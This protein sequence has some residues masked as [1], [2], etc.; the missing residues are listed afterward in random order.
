MNQID[1]KKLNETSKLI[2]TLR[3]KC[4][5]T[6]CITNFVT[7][8]DC[9][10]SVLA[11]GGSPA[12]AN[13]KEEVTEFVDIAGSLV[14]NI[15]TIFEHDQLAI[16]KAATHAKKVETPV[17]LDPVAVGVTKLRNEITKKIIE[18]SNVSIIRG[19]MSEI[20]AI[21]K[22]FNIV[23]EC[24]MAKGVDVATNDIIT[25]EN[26]KEKGQL[27]K[28]IA[29]KLNT[30]IAVS[31][32]IDIISDGKHSYAIDNGNEIMT[33][34]TGSGCMLTAV[35]GSFM[36]VTTPLNAAII[37]S[38]SMAIAGELAFKTISDNKEGTGSFRTYL[39][40]ELYKIN[41]DTI[42]KYGKLYLIE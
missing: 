31:G 13:E 20:K 38:L 11:I 10:N 12:M 23:D 32:K 29:Y 17:I 21:G 42:Q 5:L 28:N 27:V 6:H 9:A 2:D 24:T 30:V 35:I 37:G 34:I 8:N 14:I 26:I 39:I 40:D 4:P 22:L 1:N 33:K 18:E 7:V 3:K 36:A 19:N 25:K 41:E 16:M 15:G